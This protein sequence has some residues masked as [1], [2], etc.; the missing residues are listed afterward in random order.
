MGAADAE[1]VCVLA[2]A[3]GEGLYQ[4]LLSGQ[5]HLAGSLDLQA[6]GGVEHV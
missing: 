5:D 4:S 1:R 6:E 3:G 2:C